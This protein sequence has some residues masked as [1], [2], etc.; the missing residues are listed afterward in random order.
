MRGVFVA[1]LKAISER[2]TTMDKLLGWIMSPA[3]SF[4]VTGLLG[5]AITWIRDLRKKKKNSVEGMDKMSK[6]LVI[7]LREELRGRYEY[8]VNEG[9][10]SVDDFAEFEEAYNIYQE[11][12]G[13]HTVPKMYNI[14]KELPNHP[15]E[16]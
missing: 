14:L 12:G 8:F 1:P 7:L 4:I 15:L 5:I 10:I 13:N 9:W 16:K 2:T 3:F 11:L 6:A